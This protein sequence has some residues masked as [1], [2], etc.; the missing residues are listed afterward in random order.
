MAYF[1]RSGQ[2]ENGYKKTKIVFVDG[3]RVF[4]PRQGAPDFIKLNFLVDIPE[5]IKWLKTYGEDGKVRFDLK[6]SLDGK[7]YLALNSWKPEQTGIKNN[8]D[9]QEIEKTMSQNEMDKETREFDD[10]NMALDKERPTDLPF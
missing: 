6:K 8:R 2:R 5:L 4:K 7:I 10:V 1:Q 3:V 9:D